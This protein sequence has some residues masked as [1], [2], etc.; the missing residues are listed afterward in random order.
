MCKV[1]N[2]ISNEPFVYTVLGCLL[3][4]YHFFLAILLKF[5]NSLMIYF[6]LVPCYCMCMQ[7]RDINS[8]ST[9]NSGIAIKTGHIDMEI[10]GSTGVSDIIPTVM[11]Y[12]SLME[13]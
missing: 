12:Q 13:L 10:Y 1:A 6:T 2:K 8:V 4:K 11:S 7:K 5:F 3:C 9:W